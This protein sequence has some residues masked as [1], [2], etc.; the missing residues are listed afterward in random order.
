MLY[1][2]QRIVTRLQKNFYY[3]L[4]LVLL[5]V[6][7]LL[8][9]GYEFLPTAKT[10]YIILFQ[11]ID[12]MIASIFLIDFFAGLL[13]N[14]TMNTR[15]YFTHNWLNLASSI[16][17]TSDVTRALRILRV[18]RAFRIIRAGVNFWSANSRYNNRHWR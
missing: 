2:T 3:S 16:P 4:G 6:F 9:L 12:I 1:R 14:T 13:F 18:I 7:S 8:L 17:I 15:T 5:A 10:E 11:K